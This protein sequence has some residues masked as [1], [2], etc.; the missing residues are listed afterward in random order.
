MCESSPVIYNKLQIL[1]KRMDDMKHSFKHL[2][3]I[4]PL[5]SI[6]SDSI[7]PLVLVL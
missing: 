5:E 6:I 3:L 7:Q 4:S 2:L 1:Q